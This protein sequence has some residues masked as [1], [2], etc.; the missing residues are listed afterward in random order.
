MPMRSRILVALA[1]LLAV[2]ALLG[3]WVD[4]QLLDTDQWTETSA[5]LLQ[6]EAIRVPLADEISAELADGSRTTAA[7]QE[8]LPP[9]LQPLAGPAGSL[10]ADAVQRAVQRVLAS[11]R[12]QR[13]WV[14]L[15][16]VTHEQL[17][18]LV[19]GGGTV[20]A[21]RGVILDLRPLAKQVASAVGIDPA[22]VDRLP[23]PR[24][25]IVILDPERLQ[26]LR[27]AG[28]VLDTLAWL[29]GILALA[30]FALAVWLAGSVPGG[31]RRA[32]LAC[33]IGL[34]LAAL[35]V[36]VVRR[37]V[38]NQVITAVTGDGPLLDAAQAVWTIATTLLAEIAALVVAVGVLALAGAWLAGDG[39]RASALR[40]RIAP[41]L[42]GRPDLVYGIAAIA[43]LVLLAWGPLSVMQRPWAIVAFGALLL[44]GIAALRAQVVRELA[45]GDGHDAA[46]P[47]T[48]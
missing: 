9:R 13:A 3:S 11:A 38:G 41:T 43:Y 30:L 24:G 39:R 22:V 4:R 29:P 31:R 35:L 17:V 32:L 46:P 20:V 21:G 18:E 37:V 28:D 1:S 33:G 40:A 47:A 23:R 5:A 12:V 44:G 34:A 45:G 48:G 7:L 26:K 6:D 25:R 14:T 2:V 8:A 10:V 16:R 27:T 15:N 19:E 42:A 36:L